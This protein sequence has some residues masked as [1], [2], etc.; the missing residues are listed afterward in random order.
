MSIRR[1]IRRGRLTLHGWMEVRTLVDSTFSSHVP[2]T[3]QIIKNV[4]NI[5]IF[6]SV[7]LLLRVDHIPPPLRSKTHTQSWFWC[8]QG[9]DL[10]SQMSSN[11]STSQCSRSQRHPTRVSLL[12][13][14]SSSFFSKEQ[15]LLSLSCGRWKITQ[16]LG[17]RVKEILPS[18]RTR[19]NE[20]DQTL[21]LSRWQ[22]C[23]DTSPLLSTE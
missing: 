1:G 14:F 19:T 21:D 23:Q 4:N 13:V 2:H 6:A 18:L 12:Q 9:H 20:A 11:S 17:T 3:I 16:T 5:Q 15:M 22:S 10:N 8:L 7:H